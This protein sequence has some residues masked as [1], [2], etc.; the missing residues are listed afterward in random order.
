MKLSSQEEYGLR[1]M[2]F[3]ADST[4]EVSRTIPEISRAEGI[5]RHNVAKMLNILRR[6]ELVNSVR[7]QNGGYILARKPEHIFVSEILAVL[8]S[9]LFAPDFCDH[10]S[11]ASENCNHQNSNCSLAALWNRMQIAVD[12]VVDQL[13]LKDLKN[14][15]FDISKTEDSHLVNISC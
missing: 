13:T 14:Q 6:G 15:N 5:T 10:F 7:G 11:G 3:L 1:C 12:Q 2:L 8:G 9:P 4:C